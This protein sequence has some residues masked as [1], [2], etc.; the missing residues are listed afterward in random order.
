[1]TRT[2]RRTITVLG[3]AAVLAAPAVVLRALCVGRSCDEAVAPQVDVPFCS[4]PGDLR[5]R[6]VAGFRDGRSPDIMAVATRET[7]VGGADGYRRLQP[8]WPALGSGDASRVPLAFAS[9]GARADVPGGVT[10]NR[11]APTIAR[12]MGIQRPFPEVRSGTPIENVSIAQPPRLT[13][14]V[15]WKGIGSRDLER[16]PDAWPS[17][18]SLLG[19]GGTL[20]ADVGSLPVDPTAVLTTIGTGGLPAEHGITGSIVRGEDG[21]AV[22]SWSEAAPFSVIATLADDLD[23]LLGQEPRIGVIGTSPLDRG[24]IGR[25]W[26]VEHDTD[27]ALVVRSPGKAVDAVRSLLADGYGADEVPDLLALVLEGPV[28][29]MDRATREAAEAA[30]DATVRPG[31]DP[32]TLLVVTSTG[33]MEP[34]PLSATDLVT[35][36]AEIPGVIEAV[37]TGGVF[38]DQQALVQADGTEDVVIRAIRAI[39]TPEGASVFADVFSGTA[40]ELAGFCP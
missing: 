39:R 38:L 16:L 31:A 10:L 6:L 25:E 40:I 12:A 29:A 2:T 27:D 24:V 34:S 8:T 37:A 36:A 9:A 30:I 1:M 35:E 23:D 28:R 18:R 3:L 7:P 33:S 14:L 5:A 13:L 11:V 21:R 15:V 20:D 4:L 17:L 19:A 26:Y 32:A 22:R